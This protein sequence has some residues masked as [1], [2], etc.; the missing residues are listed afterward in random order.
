GLALQSQLSI[1]HVTCMQERERAWFGAKAQWHLP[2]A[3]NSN[4]NGNK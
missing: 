2:S 3:R 1:V 4:H